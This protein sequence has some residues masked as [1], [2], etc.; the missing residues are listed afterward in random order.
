MIKR[1][2]KQIATWTKNL[3]LLHFSIIS[4]IEQQINQISCHPEGVRLKIPPFRDFGMNPKVKVNVCPN[5]FTIFLGVS[6]F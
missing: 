3:G 5:C 6:S 4:L 1:E 2:V